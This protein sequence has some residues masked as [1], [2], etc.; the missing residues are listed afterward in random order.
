M[1]QKTAH[2]FP[3][4]TLPS[5]VHCLIVQPLSNSTILLFRYIAACF[6]TNIPHQSSITLEMVTL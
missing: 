2:A 4:T 5:A 1:A 3:G 6:K